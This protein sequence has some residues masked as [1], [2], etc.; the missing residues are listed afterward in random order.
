MT[1]EVNSILKA[2]LKQWAIYRHI[3]AND[4]GVGYPRINTIGR[5]MEPDYFSREGNLEPP[6]DWTPEEAV[7]LE[8]QILQLL[9]PAAKHA[10]E[11]DALGRFQKARLS[12][13]VA[14]W[15]NEMRKT[16][17]LDWK[18]K[19]QRAYRDYKSEG[20]WF[21]AGRLLLANGADTVYKYSMPEVAGM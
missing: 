18:D 17:G 8:M 12:D 10:V 11:A 7:D 9:H 1:P 19:R 15:N 13:R 20:H 3:V 14:W 5:I 2:R 4:T 16:L 21:L 6:R